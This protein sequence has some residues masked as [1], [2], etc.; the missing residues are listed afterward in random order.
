MALKTEH[1]HWKKQF[2]EK[3]LG[4][5]TIKKEKLVN[6]VPRSLNVIFEAQ[7]LERQNKVN[8]L[9]VKIPSCPS[10]PQKGPQR[11]RAQE[12]LRKVKKEVE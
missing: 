7:M 4:S 11:K 12:E 3:Y 10:E 9:D 2:T 1:E 6:K 5:T 8:K